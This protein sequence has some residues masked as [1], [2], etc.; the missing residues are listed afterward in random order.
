[1]G[2][3]YRKTAMKPLPADAEIFIRQGERFARWKDRAGKT[4][5]APL[6]LTKN[7]TNRIV[8]DDGLA[9]RSI[10]TALAWYVKCRPAAGTKPPHNGCWGTSSGG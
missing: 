9:R 10:G 6:T 3:V 4:R 7:G 2:T 8:V 5:T 1:M